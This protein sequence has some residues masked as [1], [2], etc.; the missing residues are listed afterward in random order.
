MRVLVVQEG[1]PKQLWGL[2]SL[3]DVRQVCAFLLLLVDWGHSLRGAHRSLVLEHGRI[4]NALMTVHL[5]LG[6]VMHHSL[7]NLMVVD[8]LEHLILLPKVILE[9]VLSHKW[10][11][12]TIESLLLLLHLLLHL[13]H[14]ELLLLLLCAWILL[15]GHHVPLRQVHRSSLI[16]GLLSIL[17]LKQGRLIIIQVDVVYVEIGGVVLERLLLLEDGLLLRHVLALLRLMLLVHVLL[18]WICR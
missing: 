9:H 17:C 14:Q 8:V 12:A 6:L 11:H 10:T 1:V 7:S 4:L 16:G 3:A 13:L 15:L 18:Y 2:A 5:I